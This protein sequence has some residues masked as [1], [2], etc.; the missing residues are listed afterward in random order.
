[1]Q[2]TP[3]TESEKFLSLSLDWMCTVFFFFWNQRTSSD[4]RQKISWGTPWEV[5]LPPRIHRTRSSSLASAA[6]E[7]QPAR[8]GRADLQML[9]IVFLRKKLLCKLVSLLLSCKLSPSP[10]QPLIPFPIATSLYLHFPFL[11]HLSA[12]RKTSNYFQLQAEC[13]PLGALQMQ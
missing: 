12:S 1:M 10:P 11:R 6:A 4:G 5:V 13:C 2:A 8:A 3:S 7:D 9:S